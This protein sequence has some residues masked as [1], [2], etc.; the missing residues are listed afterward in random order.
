MT[1]SKSNYLP[2][3][4]P[5]PAITL[6]TRASTYEWEREEEGKHSAR[7]RTKHIKFS[8]CF[9]SFI[10]FDVYRAE[11]CPEEPEDSVTE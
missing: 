1:L 2:K 9:T 4:P 10:Q 6:E 7:A 11:S 8:E 3:A 5:P